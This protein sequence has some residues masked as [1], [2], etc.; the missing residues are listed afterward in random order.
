VLG[1]SSTLCP[2]D[3]GFNKSINKGKSKDLYVLV[4]RKS[5]ATGGTKLTFN[6]QTTSATCGGSATCSDNVDLTGAITCAIV[7]SS[8]NLGTKEVAKFTV[9]C[10]DLAGD[11]VSCK[12]SN[13]NWNNGLKGGFIEKDSS[14]ALAYTTSSQGSK[15]TLKYS[16]GIALCKSNITVIKPKYEC[17]FIPSSAKLSPLQSK[18]FRLNCFVSGSS[19]EPDDAD[20]DR[21]EGLGGSTSNSSTKGTNYNAPTS[22]TSGK[23]RGYG[24]WNIPGDDPILGAVAFAPIT[25]S[26]NQT[27]ATNV[28]NGGGT[29]EE[30]STKWCTISSGTLSTFPGA[31]GWVPIKCGPKANKTCSGVVWNSITGGTFLSPSNNYGTFFNVTGKVG[32]SGRINA[33]VNNDPKQYCYKPFTIGKPAC[34]EFS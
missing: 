16:S 18:Y 32:T 24:Y 13:W 2:T 4:F 12:G 14:K 3:N 28:T 19:S 21:I 25:V 20:Y 26:G 27:N 29:G 5:G 1:F 9:S 31:V 23:L 22:S 6:A 17:E 11:P 7:P 10:Q 15:G 30:G 34:W 33:Y 8:L